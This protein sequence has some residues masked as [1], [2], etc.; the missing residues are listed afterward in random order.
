M[1][2]RKAEKGLK[3]RGEASLSDYKI[4][5]AELMSDSMKGEPDYIL[6][7]QIDFSCSKNIQLDCVADRQLF[8]QIHHLLLVVHR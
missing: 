5:S 7:F 2:Q 6:I 8:W 4:R 1:P 3:H